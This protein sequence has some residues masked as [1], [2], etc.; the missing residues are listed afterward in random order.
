MLFRSL[1]RLKWPGVND[2]DLLAVGPVN[3]EDPDAS[4]GHPQVE[5]PGLDRK[6]GRIRQQTDRERIFE[7]FFDIPLRQRAAHIEGRIS[8][9]KLHKELI[10]NSSAMQ[11]SYI[12]FTHWLPFCQQVFCGNRYTRPERGRK[13][14]KKDRKIKYGRGARR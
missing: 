12:V 3:T 9:I 11:C 6:P 8:P 4:C 2:P 5:K 14:R 10:V 1:F 13:E 7:R